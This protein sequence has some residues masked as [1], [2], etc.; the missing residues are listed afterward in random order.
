MK[1][2]LL[3]M[4][5]AVATG[6]ALAK[7][8]A[9][10][11]PAWPY[12]DYGEAMKST[13]E[14]PLTAVWQEKERKAIDEATSDAVLASFV[15]DEEA[16]RLLLLKVEGAFKTDPLTLTQIAAVTQWVMMDDEWYH[17]FWKG[18]HA[19]GRKIWTE[20][21][22]ELADETDNPYIKI[23][24]LDQLRLCAY[25][26]QVEDIIEIGSDSKNMNVRAVAE[27]VARGLKKLK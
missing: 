18:P 25:P 27:Y 6:M 1:K 14:K 24:C 12:H 13:A 11:D 26:C 21:L 4:T 20:E 5:L 2:L 3:T 23:F 7:G 15:A 9:E 19:A 16:A 8:D 22:L 10:K 17:L